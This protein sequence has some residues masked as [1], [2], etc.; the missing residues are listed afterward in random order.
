MQAAATASSAPLARFQS[1]RIRRAKPAADALV[2]LCA[3]LD[4]QIVPVSRR[5][6]YNE[7]TAKATLADILAQHGEQHFVLLIRTIVESEGNARALV[8][9]IIWA[10]SDIMLAFPGWPSS[11]L[12]WIEAFDAIELQ[13]LLRLARPLCNVSKQKSRAAIGGMLVQRLQPVF[14]KGLKRMCQVPAR[15]RM[16]RAA[17]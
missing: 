4:V 3:A 17:Y 14:G 10:V 15:R 16:G 6:R 11:G 1:K 9:P 2:R 13:S 7:T 12:A 5:P 8:A